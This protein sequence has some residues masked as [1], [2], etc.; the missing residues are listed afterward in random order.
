MLALSMLA[1]GYAVATVMPPLPVGPMAPPQPIST[2]PKPYFSWDTIPTSYHGKHSPS[3]LQSW[4]CARIGV[5]LDMR[6]LDMRELVN[7]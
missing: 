7:V 6:E 1:A 3:K 5:D 2:I 4:H